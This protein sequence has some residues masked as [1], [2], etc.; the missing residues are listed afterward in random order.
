MIGRQIGLR[1]C[2]PWG[3]GQND[4]S[5]H[6]CYRIGKLYCKHHDPEERQ[7]KL[8]EWEMEMQT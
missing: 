3:Y 5:G 2:C 8:E 4:Y 1:Q 7:R 6:Q